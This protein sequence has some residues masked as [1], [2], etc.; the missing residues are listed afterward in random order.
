MACAGI[1]TIKALKSGE[2]V[3][4]QSPAR[5]GYVCI[6]SNIRC[7]FRTVTDNKLFESLH[8][9]SQSWGFTSRS[10]ARVILGQV[11][12]IAKN[13]LPLDIVYF[14]LYCLT[15]DKIKYSQM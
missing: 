7:G 3:T 6:A 11:L 9:Q 10:T 12:R 5:G 1:Q 4:Q 14:K 13:V 2:V 8:K 15:F